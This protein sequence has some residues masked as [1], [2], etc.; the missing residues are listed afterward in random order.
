ML[1]LELFVTYVLPLSVTFLL[2]S[3][4][5]SWKWM[6]V[7]WVWILFPII[8]LG[9]KKIDLN[10]IGISI[11]TWRKSLLQV[12]I[13]TIIVFP[14]FVSLFFIYI[15]ICGYTING[16]VVHNDLWQYLLF[17][18][19]F[20]S[21]PEEFFFR[22]YFQSTIADAFKKSPKN[23]KVIFPI[24]LSAMLFS[25]THIILNP[26]LTSFLT[27]FPGL[28]FGLLKERTDSLIAPIVFHWECN[29]LW[30]YLSMT[31]S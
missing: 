29:I 25:V 24:I 27:F 26:S 22:G 11:R 15:K 21:I 3:E 16:F 8:T 20:V 23:I 14:L 30:Y 31:I 7:P 18:L 2:R 10:K 6:I 12:F 19:L 4:Q 1:Y 17:H 13:A 5:H 9:I 28:I